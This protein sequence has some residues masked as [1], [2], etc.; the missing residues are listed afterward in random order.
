MP[1]Y[2]LSLNT[3]TMG[4]RLS[5]STMF[6]MAEE[7]A[8]HSKEIYY[9]MEKQAA[10]SYRIGIDD[11]RMK[12]T[13]P[14]DDEENSQREGFRST[15]LVSEIS[16]PAL[17]EDREVKRSAKI[18][19]FKTGKQVAGEF[20]DEVLEYR[21]KE[22]PVIVMSDAHKTNTAKKYFE[23]CNQAYCLVHARRYFWEIQDNYPEIV[24]EILELFREIFGVEKYCRENN[25]FGKSRLKE[26]EKTSRNMM[27]RIWWICRS[28]LRKKKAE[29]NSSLGKAMKYFLTHFVFLC[30]FLKVEDCP[31]DN[32]ES[33]R[34]LKRLICHRKNSM[35]YRS[36][37]GSG[38][39]D[40]IMSLGFSAQTAGIDP[41][42]YFED[43]LLNFNKNENIQNWLPWNWAQNK[44]LN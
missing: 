35:F 16:P 38:V 20:L 23:N 8:N 41:Q 9:E 2:R 36:E 15:V 26:H 29:P 25:L 1:H 39:G 22:G 43:I 11:T 18:C 5:T 44:K 24:P 42:K 27:A 33:E 10:N 12:I 30:R 13:K 34:L 37:V 14:M 19:L 7:L 17:D 6:N 31:L 28:W 32:N 4:I 40:I 21:N 3:A